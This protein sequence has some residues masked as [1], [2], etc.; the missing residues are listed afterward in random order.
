MN[1]LNKGLVYATHLNNGVPEDWNN[2]DPLTYSYNANGTHSSAPDRFDNSDKAIQIANRGGFQ[3]NN[4]LYPYNHCTIS[5]WIKSSNVIGNS[6]FFGNYN[7]D[8]L[9]FLSIGF[10]TNNIWVII[11][12]G[13]RYVEAVT[14]KISI[15]P[16]I[17]YHIV[18]VVKN[19]M[20]IDIYI[21]GV[22]QSFPL[23]NTT[24][25]EEFIDFYIGTQYRDGTYN[26]T[27]VDATIDELRVYDRPLTEFEVIGLY[28]NYDT[29]FNDTGYFL[30]NGLIYA[31]HLSGD[32]E[33]WTGNTTYE[34]IDD[35]VLINTIDKNGIID[36]ALHFESASIH[37]NAYVDFINFSLSVWV[38]SLS[39]A[40]RK[41]FVGNYG[42]VNGFIV[43]GCHNNNYI[44]GMLQKGGTRYA[45]FISSSGNLKDNEWNHVV[46]TTNHDNIKIYINGV[47]TEYAW[48]TKPSI[49]IG[50]ELYYGKMNGHTTKTTTQ[51][52]YCDLDEIRLYNRTLSDEEINM[53]YYGYD[54]ELDFYNT[55]G[56]D[57]I[58]GY[59]F[60][61]DYTDFS[62]NENHLTPEVSNPVFVNDV[63]NEIN[64]AIEIN[65]NGLITSA[66]T[67][68]Y[69][70]LGFSMSLWYKIDTITTGYKY[71]AND[72]DS[73]KFQFGIYNQTKYYISI[74]TNGTLITFTSS[75]AYTIADGNWHHLTYFYNSSITDKIQIYLDGILLEK[76]TTGSGLVDSIGNIEIGY[77]TDNTNSLD[78]ELDEI[79][80]YDRALTEYEII[81]LY[82]EYG[83]T[84]IGGGDEPSTPINKSNI[85]NYL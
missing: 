84:D 52:L 9:P 75:N 31:S 77:Y 29:E 71:F 68:Q 38:K 47:K 78:S 44:T 67:N 19:K 85:I 37:A 74:Y 49:G 21:N 39:F 30:N 83:N 11:Q 35:N 28:N 16:D 58:C 23:S 20:G 8:S 69:K 54:T 73:S 61:G 18:V 10:G 51:D 56:N 36:S 22:K 6:I 46:I 79:R 27:Y 66:I 62:G 14:N 41:Y 53:L 42:D 24:I 43:L 7:I 40:I 13:V 48:S 57:L 60:S 63:N 33:D 80:F 12:K 76:S 81:R 1:T 59:H 25:T 70:R 55:L 45:E 50:S 72:N 26:G 17:W 3:V 34:I 82:L 32:G 2:L 64:K 4:R 5:M 65:Q 15:Q